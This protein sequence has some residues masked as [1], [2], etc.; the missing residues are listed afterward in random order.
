MSARTAAWSPDGTTIAFGSGDAQKDIGLYLMEADGTDV[1]RLGEVSGTWLVVHAAGLVAGWQEH[2][3]HRRP[4]DPDPHS[5]IWVF[6]SDGSAETMVSEAPEGPT[7]LGPAYAPDGALAWW[8]AG[9]CSRWAARRGRWQASARRR[10]SPDGQFIVTTDERAAT[11]RR[12]RDHRPR[13]HDRDDDRGRRR[14][15]L[16]WQRLPG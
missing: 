4:G 16:S 9:G 8:V 13:R 6:A 12:S 2:R 3:G 15:R 11:C 10:W 7:E 5:D 1:R 14:R